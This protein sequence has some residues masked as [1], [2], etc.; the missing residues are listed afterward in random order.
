MFCIIIQKKM[1]RAL[2]SWIEILKR[3]FEGVKFPSSY[4]A[5]RF[6]FGK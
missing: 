3:D 4:P 6:N 1:S 5:E 2:D